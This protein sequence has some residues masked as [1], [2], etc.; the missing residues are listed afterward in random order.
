[1][2]KIYVVFFP[3]PSQGLSVGHD[4]KLCYN[5]WTDQGAIRDVH[6]GGPK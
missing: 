6:L 3:V 2:V 5:G 4:C 1:M